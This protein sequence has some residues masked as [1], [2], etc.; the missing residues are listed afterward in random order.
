MFAGLQRRAPLKAV[1]DL[2]GV[3]AV[4]ALK[5]AVELAVPVAGRER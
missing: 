2:L 1:L 4:V 3:L 5:V